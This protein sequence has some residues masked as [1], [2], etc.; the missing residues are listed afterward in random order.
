M[1][2]RIRAGFL[3]AAVFVLGALAMD[4][5][6]AF[7]FS[8]Y[9]IA[10]L[11]EEDAPT[12]QTTRREANLLWPLYSSR[13]DAVGSRSG[14]HPLW[15]KH[16]NREEGTRGLDIL[17]PL[18]SWKERRGPE[19]LDRQMIGLPLW[20]SI[21]RSFPTGETRQWRG[22]FPL[23]YQG[24]KT[25]PDAED[26]SY[27]ICFPFWWR[28]DQHRLLFPV[29]WTEPG[30]SFAFFP[31]YGRF[32]RFLLFD[33][34]RF[35]GWPLW[36]QTQRKDVHVY[37]ALWPFLAYAT[38]DH[39]WGFRLW[40][41]FGSLPHPDGT[42]RYF[43]LWPLGE[44]LNF[45]RGPLKGATLNMFLP[46]WFTF[47][48]QKR[49][50]VYYF[51]VYGHS[52]SPGRVSR[53]WFWPVW[54]HAQNFKPSYN[55][56]YFMWFVVSRQIGPGPERRFHLLNLLGWTIRPDFK[57]VHVF[58]PVASYRYDRVEQSDGCDFAR[59]Y[60]VPFLYWRTHQWDDGRTLKYRMIWP[61]ASWG[62]DK[63]RSHL[64]IPDLF[65]HNADD[66]VGRNWAPLWSLYARTCDKELNR[67]E[68]RFLGPL[69]LTRK[70]ESKD[71]SEF[72][73]LFFQYKREGTK[74]KVSLL[75]GWLP[76]TL[77][78]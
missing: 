3:M 25:F 19:Q 48:H 54:A 52:K 5:A 68:T 69:Y 11:H 28:F 43:W 22:L 7:S 37:S 15:S 8:F 34:V 18:V 72:N 24:R 66:G 36:V 17:W 46:F 65:P 41:L 6:R 53:A 38:S 50:I 64:T 67:R 32:E 57:R 2:A 33:M 29:Y 77:T 73:L 30:Q 71:E 16:E 70:D 20:Y 62:H 26:R 10:Y 31:F 63:E 13:S 1:N 55:K 56:Y 4:N 47:H 40:P 9:P 78:G 14:L 51:P 42:Q 75:F 61:L 27:S 76:Y 35:I 58:W 60:F 21:Y 74:R 49:D 39:G 59:Y 44:K 23:F 12:T 45:A